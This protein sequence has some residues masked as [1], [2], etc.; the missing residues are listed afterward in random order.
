M[1]H[2]VIGW[3]LALMLG[4]GLVAQPAQA[5]CDYPQGPLG[6]GGE[7]LQAGTFSDEARQI[8]PDFFTY[9]LDA[10][11]PPLLPSW[12]VD[13]FNVDNDGNG[14]KDTDHMELL[15]AVRD[16]NATAVAGI[17]SGTVTTIRNAYTANR[18]AVYA[19]EL[20]I[21]NVN[22]AANIG[23]GYTSL[24][25]FT[26]TTGSNLTLPIV[27]AQPIPSLWTVEEQLVNPG[28][29]GILSSAD[30][31]LE[32]A[33]VD[34]LSSMMTIADAATVT[35]MQ[36]TMQSFVTL[37]ITTALEDLLAGVGDITAFNNTLNLGAGTGQL[38][39][40]LSL[41][42]TPVRV[43][44]PAAAVNTAI[45][46]FKN[47]FTCTNFTCVTALTTAGN[48]NGSGSANGTAYAAAAAPKRT[49]WIVAKGLAFAPPHFSPAP[50]DFTGGTGTNVQLDGAYGVVGG[51][52]STRSYDWERVYLNEPGQQSFDIFDPAITGT[53]NTQYYTLT[54]AQQT[55]SGWYSVQHCDTVY[56]RIAPPFFVTI[57][58]VLPRVSAVDVTG[59]ST[60]EVTF[61]TGMNGVTAGNTSNYTVS[62]AGAGTFTANP[63][64]VT[65]LASNRYQLTWAS[66]EMQQGGNVTVTVN[67]SVLSDQG[68]AMTSPFS[69]TDV[70]GG[71]GTAP[72]VTDI[73]TQNAG[74]TAAATIAHTVTFSESVIGEADTN[75]SVVTVSG[76]ATG[77]ISPTITGTGNTRTVTIENITGAG[78]IRLSLS[79]VGSITDLANNLLSNTLTNDVDAVSQV[80]RVAPAVPSVPDMT[81]GTDTGL[82]NSDNVTN[83]QTPTFTGTG[84][85]GS[86]VDL[87]AKPSNAV[88]GSGVVSGGGTYSITAS[89]LA[90][91]VTGIAA[92]ARDALSN[93]SAES[94]ALTVT[95]DITAP[96]VPSI[97]DLTVGT[98]SGS[99]NSDNITR[100]VPDGTLSFTGTRDNNTRVQLFRASDLVTP[101][102]TDSGAGTAY[103]VTATGIF[104]EGLRGF[105]A[106][107]I[108][109]AGNESALSGSL[110]VTVDLTAPTISALNPADNAT[111]GA[112]SQLTVTFIESVT[113][114]AAGNL[115]YAGSPAG[116]VS[117]SG[118]GPYTFT[119]LSTPADG[120]VAVS[121]AAGAIT[122]VAGN[123]FG[124]FAW[125]Y[126]KNTSNPSVSLTSASVS[127]GGITNN[128]AVVITASFSEPVLGSGVNGLLIGDIQVTNGTLT[129]LTGFGST[130]DTFTFRV[131]PNGGAQPN[132]PITVTIPFD[133]ADGSNPAPNRG[134]FASNTFAF[135]F[136][137]VAPTVTSITPLTLGPTNADTIFHTVT[138]NGPV[139]G[140]DNAAD[141][142]VILTDTANNVGANII[143]NTAI[144]Y[145]VELLNVTGDGTV[146]LFILGGVA[147]DA[148]GNG[149]TSQVS[150][151]PVVIDNTAPAVTVN[152][153]L[154]Q[155]STPTLT[156]TVDDP[157][158]TVLVTAGG[159]TK[160]AS[161]AGANWTVNGAL[162]T[163]ISDGQYDVLASAT[164][165]AGNAGTDVTTDELTI[166][167]QDPV[168]TL[169]G[170]TFI[171]L[172]CGE[173][174]TEEGIL[175]ATDNVDGDV[176]AG[177]V[178]S[179]SVPAFSPPGTYDIEYTA[180]D[181]V[182][183]ETTVVR[184]VVILS[185]C[186]LQVDLL[187]PN[188]IEREG[189]ESVTFEVSATNEQPPGSLSFQWYRVGGSKADTLIGDDSPTL[190]LTDLGAEDIANYYC[191]VSDAVTTVN[192]GQITLQVN[193]TL[194]IAGGLGMAAL[195]SAIAIAGSTLLRR[196]K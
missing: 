97:P 193:I 95:I 16:G 76:T 166:D 59:P 28:D 124:S 158:A 179:I 11:I 177:V 54:S 169:N 4:L 68:N 165:E 146:Q 136:D 167:T 110:S 121:L 155:D 33:F 40:F 174:Y 35:Y 150:F 29:K 90:E 15:A 126:T 175:S 39:V 178:P 70:G 77:T 130:T 115:T 117:G 161:I 34:Y 61:N 74:P 192:S 87:I 6:P 91:S 1:K 142:T 24:G 82:L 157:A 189:G 143:Q 172:N 187:V 186:T 63:T 131:N 65:Q 195:A 93:T 83:N 140:F 38:E 182:G 52:P 13:T 151:F 114:V 78:Q 149:N 190:T 113:G 191:S 141:L 168:I 153:L 62:G 119:G 67:G 37:F 176:S 134:N 72:T 9:V 18:S 21:P 184:Q 53:T 48:L 84:E 79:S 137:N 7:V 196:R 100:G 118:V 132:L 139:V 64:S 20:S 105:R 8:D 106:K 23:L 122:D 58:T 71:I 89:T 123:A 73:L 96:S 156:G 111:V 32:M 94:S 36:N 162:F 56:R 133:A 69:G 185:N 173:G 163:S 46:T 125:D 144:Q 81:S 109:V 188:F 30:V 171:V 120:P 22:L 55:Q 145:S 50:A 49:N 45:S 159:Q 183:N 147:T 116:G 92:R 51:S 25:N 98:D 27:G 104:D 154:T 127:D 148:A 101:L 10:L 164:D 88:V 17:P 57:G 194:P 181:S 180:V 107:A 42:G 60:V 41:D 170:D 102:N 160:T 129:A 47:R 12:T 44:I 5:Q 103:S 86:T 2:A 66:G 75:F 14:I 80:D 108:D 112:I 19:T 3:G 99:S 31:M 43:R 152:S 135:T 85:A 26:V 138:F 128:N